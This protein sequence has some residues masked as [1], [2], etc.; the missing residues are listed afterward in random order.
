MT[1]NEIGV[2]RNILLKQRKKIMEIDDLYE[3]CCKLETVNEI[4]D[5]ILRYLVECEV[6]DRCEYEQLH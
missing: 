1:A 2:L 3:S 6:G 5:D 4:Y